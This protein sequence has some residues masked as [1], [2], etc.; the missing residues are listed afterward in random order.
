M[1]ISSRI[2]SPTLNST[3]YG[4]VVRYACAGAIEEAWPTVGEVVATANALGCTASVESAPFSFLAVFVAEDVYDCL[5]GYVS[6]RSALLDSYPQIT[7]FKATF[8]W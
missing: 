3:V 7:E 4:L 1:S 8:P 6:L 2:K 5:L